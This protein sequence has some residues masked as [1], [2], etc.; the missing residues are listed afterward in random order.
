MVD[1]SHNLAAYQ[2]GEERIEAD[3]VIGLTCSQSDYVRFESI[4]EAR[5][6][7]Q[8]MQLMF[9]RN[10]H[11]PAERRIVNYMVGQPIENRF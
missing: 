8:K 6:D 2:A 7:S 5:S 1:S 3:Q 10:M 9:E 11:L 4:P